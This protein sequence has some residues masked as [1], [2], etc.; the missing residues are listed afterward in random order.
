MGPAVVVRLSWCPAVPT[1]CCPAVARLPCCWVLTL[2]TWCRSSNLRFRRRVSLGSPPSLQQGGGHDAGGVSQAVQA[3]RTHTPTHHHTL[4]LLQFPVCIPTAAGCAAEGCAAGSPPPPAGPTPA[5]C[6]CC[7]CCGC[8]PRVRAPHPAP[9]AAL[10]SDSRRGAAPPGPGARRSPGSHSSRR[11]SPA[12]REGEGAQGAAPR[13]LTGACT[14]HAYDQHRM[15][16]R[17]L[18]C[19]RHCRSHVPA[20]SAPLLQLLQ[21]VH[22]RAGWKQATPAALWRNSRGYMHTP[23]C[24]GAGVGGKAWER[25]RR[26]LARAAAGVAHSLGSARSTGHAHGRPSCPAPLLGLQQV[27]PH[28]RLLLLVVEAAPAPGAVLVAATAGTP[29]LCA[30]KRRYC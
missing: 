27:P 8:A 9:R 1:P 28:V 4:L 20:V 21:W 19:S 12:G 24:G 16:T 5:R 13:G 3:P 7:C 30:I 10:G 14:W 15:L 18:G 22:A 6:C 23:T 29:T 2:G 17:L 25:L 26:G 11:L